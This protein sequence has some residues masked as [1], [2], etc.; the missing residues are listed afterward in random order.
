MAV[1]LFAKRYFKL[2]EAV[3][4]KG[5]DPEVENLDKDPDM[6]E[7]RSMF[8][9]FED[10]EEFEK[11]IVNNDIFCEEDDD[12]WKPYYSVSTYYRKRNVTFQKVENWLKEHPK[13]KAD[14]K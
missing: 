8:K 2:M 1:N 12:W 3:K 11:Q 10:L 6:I 7:L 14:D 5:L 9:F 13:R 4:K